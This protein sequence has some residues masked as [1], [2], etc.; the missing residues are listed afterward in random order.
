MQASLVPGGISAAINEAGATSTPSGTVRVQWGAT[1]AR[2]A[3]IRDGRT[4]EVLSFAR[5]GNA[6]IRTGAADLEVILSDG[7]R[8]TRREIRVN[9]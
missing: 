6:Q 2:M 4:G 7:V 9:R 1:A 8:S 3:L 5:G